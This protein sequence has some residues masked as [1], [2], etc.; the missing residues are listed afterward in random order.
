VSLLMSDA[1]LAIAR[2]AVALL[3]DAQFLFEHG[4]YPRAA[5]LAVP[6]AE[7]AGKFWLP[8]WEL[9]N[10]RRK[11]Y[12]HSDKIAVSARFL[13]AEAQGLVHPT[14]YGMCQTYINAAD[15]PEYTQWVQRARD[16]LPKK[17]SGLYV[18]V[19]DAVELTNDPPVAI[20]HNAAAACIDYARSEV[21]RLYAAEIVRNSLPPLIS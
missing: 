14:T 13:S 19:D 8:K 18:D 3:N 7:E 17:L 21:Q 4:R 6:A 11:F 5:A 2:N 10:W 20:G 12:E 16:F 1:L 15:S 9:K